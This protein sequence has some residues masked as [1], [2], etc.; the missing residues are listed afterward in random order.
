MSADDLKASVGC[1]SGHQVSVD[2]RL[3]P[4]SAS[5]VARSMPRRRLRPPS[6]R[7]PARAHR[8]AQPS[9]PIDSH[10]PPPHPAGQG[11]RRVQCGAVCRGGGALHRRNWRRP[12]Q[13]CP[14]LQPL[15]GARF[16]GRVRTRAR[17]RAEGAVCSLAQRGQQSAA[18]T[19]AC[20]LSPAGSGSC[21]AHTRRPAL[22]PCAE[23]AAA[24]APDRPRQWPPMRR[25]CI[26]HRH[27]PVVQV[28]QLKSDWPKGYSRLG[29]AHYGLRRWEQAAEAYG[30]GASRGRCRCV[31]GADAG[32]EAAPVGAGGRGVRQGCVARVGGWRGWVGGDQ[33][34]GGEAQ[35]M[36]QLGRRR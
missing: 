16:D 30:K 20:M 12:V 14:L 15:G 22:C 18:G 3:R 21:K 24:R 36:Q 9:Q 19:L 29:A 23:R 10:V 7:R 33:G 17:G 5:I 26:A 34:G 27:P 4:P 1:C 11:Q 8:Q 32:E 25:M 35:A 13:P 31:G 28:V 2:R 6:G